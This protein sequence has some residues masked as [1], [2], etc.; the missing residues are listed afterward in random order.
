MRIIVNSSK[1]EV[2]S[3]FYKKGEIVKPKISPFTFFK[4]FTQSPRVNP[5]PWRQ[6][7]FEERQRL[8]QRLA[9]LLAEGT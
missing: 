8:R 2:W 7:G 6:D 3:I 4:N 1:Y 9:I 5:L